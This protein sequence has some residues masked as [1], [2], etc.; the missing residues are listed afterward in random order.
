MRKILIAITASILSTTALSTVD[1]GVEVLGTTPT[2]TQIEM[3]RAGAKK[4]CSDIEDYEAKEQCAMD[5]Y[6]HHN[7]EGEPDCE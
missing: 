7:F 5:Y 4:Y 2:E 1:D 3:V 6:A